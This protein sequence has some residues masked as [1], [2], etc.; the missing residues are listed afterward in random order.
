[1][2]DQFIG[3]YQPEDGGTVYHTPKGD[4]YVPPKEQSQQVSLEQPSYP[5]E[6][7]VSKEHIFHTTHIEH[8]HYNMNNC[9]EVTYR[10]GKT[11]TIPDA[12]NKIWNSLQEVLSR[13][14]Q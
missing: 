1:M 7:V 10:S 9:I 12:S 5:P 3:G 4:V 13:G 14:G 6:W 11:Y 8:I 2:H